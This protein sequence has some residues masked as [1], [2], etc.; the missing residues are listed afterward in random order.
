[1]AD[2]KKP[3]GAPFV[4]T[5]DGRVFV[6]N[7][8][9][10][11]FKLDEK[12]AAD[13][14]ARGDFD[15]ATA[16][17]VERRTQELNTSALGAAA[18]GVAS[19]TVAAAL[20][21]PKLARAAAPL[22]PESLRRGARKASELAGLGPD[23]LGE[24]SGKRFLE[25][26]AAVGAHLT[27]GESE[28]AGREQ[29]EQLRA[30]EEFHPVATGLGEL[31]GNVIGSGGISALGRAGAGA[32]AG[33]LAA[34]GAGARAARI[35]SGIVGGVLEGAG[36]G[37]EQASEKAWL[38]NE[39]ATAEQTLAGIGMGAL[40]GGGTS[41]LLGAIATRGAG[42]AAKLSEQLA[43]ARGGT[44]AEGLE[45]AAAQA[46]GG[47]AGWVDSMGRRGPGAAEV[48]GE[49]AGMAGEEGSVIGAKGGSETAPLEG[50]DAAAGSSSRGWM[51]GL[52]HEAGR[53]ADE[54][55]V[56]DV[57]RGN[58]GALR[59]LAYGKAPTPERLR[60]VG[61]LIHE[62][63]IPGVG[64][65]SA[66]MLQIA[67][68]RTNEIGSRI[69]K[70]MEA[71]DARI[72]QE[73]AGQFAPK[74][75]EAIFP[76][77]EAL[78]TKLTEGAIL[79]QE[80][81]LANFVEQNTEFLR[82]KAASGELTASDM[83]DFRKKIDTLSKWA[84]AE[85]GPKAEAARELRRVIEKH[86]EEEVAKTTPELLADYQRAKKLYGVASWAADTLGE[87]VGTSGA[88]RM[89]S[90]TDYLTAGAALFSG[91][92]PLVAG[93]LAAGNK[94][95][96]ER[97]M[98]TA[99]VLAKQ[100]ANDAVDVAAAPLSAVPTARNL[101]TM[102]AHTEQHIS[103]GI[104]SFFGGKTEGAAPKVARYSTAAALRSSDIGKATKA[105][106]EH[107]QQVQMVAANPEVAA[108]RLAS[109]TG[110]NVAA[111]AP[112]LHAQMAAIVSRGA[113]YLLANMPAPPT[114]PDSIT[115]QL[116][117]PPPLSET[118]MHIYANRV[119]GV[120]NPLSLVDDLK[121]NKASAEKTDA[122]KTVH[123]NIF[124]RI[125]ANV[126][127]Q[128]A[129][130]KEPVPYH[131]RLLLDLA[132]DGGGSLEPSLKPQNL[133]IMDAANRAV[134]AS[135]KPPPASGRVP[136]ISGL[137]STRSAQISAGRGV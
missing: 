99:A 44:A 33:G 29:R 91:G 49:A 81:E 101:Q 8:S 54:A 119:E 10:D 97:G 102:V 64:R 13:A 56:N 107:A 110:P 47:G 62:L 21:V 57:A 131:Q 134:A 3:A 12:H 65:S 15:P 11:L 42:K 61:A 84:R 116:D 32:A 80:K 40:F 63:G 72:A 135:A 108:S 23:P 31:G 83:W 73:G 71:A 53:L 59:D 58:K 14:V 25:D 70:V 4:P 128:L 133:R 109:M 118:D 126:F 38:R 24:L 85:P 113:N 76:K 105:Y 86:I 115:P 114:D 2:E 41:G 127:A 90:P 20:T 136:K 82:D 66:D 125:R 28:V 6:R 93:A 18:R 45:G 5:D 51:S 16:G 77:I 132:L 17:E 96:R 78:K 69:G 67:E 30:D 43:E 104:G 27:G 37:A 111:V 88:N 60:E 123:P 55:I 34:L 46:E 68:Q 121:H 19:G 7:K 103:D 137:F 22:L 117:T 112:G 35:G 79:P 92:N 89:F 26:V 50:A 124:E 52:K 122:V 120:E 39:T 98:S 100:F 129:D 36:F 9:G 95:L 75:T 1:M 87:R 130:R 74:S 106:Q 94:L 48:A